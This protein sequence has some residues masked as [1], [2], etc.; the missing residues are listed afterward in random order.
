VE[1]ALFDHILLDMT[2]KFPKVI[3]KL[4]T[5]LLGYTLRNAYLMDPC[6]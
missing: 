3:V 4:V 1:F 2:V 5:Q 6:S